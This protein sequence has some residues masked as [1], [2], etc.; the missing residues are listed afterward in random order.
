MTANNNS[1]GTTQAQFTEKAKKYCA[2][3]ERCEAEVQQKLYALGVHQTLQQKILR[4]LKAED[5]I[6]NARFAKLFVRGKFENN[7]WGRLKIRAALQAKK[8]DHPT[9]EMAMKTIEDEQYKVVLKDLM[10][11]KAKTLQNEGKGNMKERIAAFAMQRGF[12][13][14]IIRETLDQIF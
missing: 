3:R 1:I 8:I 14:A 7:G 11:K 6:D 10:A 4:N 5:Y 9:I 2:Y 13:A 12:E